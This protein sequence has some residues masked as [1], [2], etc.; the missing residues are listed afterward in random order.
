MSLRSAIYRYS[1]GEAIRCQGVGLVQYSTCTC[2]DLISTSCAYPDYT[3][4]V[5]R[6]EILDIV[7]GLPRQAFFRG[8]LGIVSAERP[9]KVACRRKGTKENTNRWR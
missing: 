9:V 1:S 7:P 5:Q 6:P 4:P 3:T 2:A 8:D